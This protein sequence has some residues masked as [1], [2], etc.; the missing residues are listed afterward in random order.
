[1]LSGSTARGWRF[2]FLMI[3][4]SSAFCL[5]TQFTLGRGWL[6]PVHRFSICGSTFRFSHDF[7]LISLLNFLPIA[8]TTQRIPFP[9]TDSCPLKHQ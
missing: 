9:V 3:F 8:S 4:G 7:Y 1:M 2:G 5:L 6:L